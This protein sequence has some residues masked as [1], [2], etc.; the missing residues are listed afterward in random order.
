VYIPICICPFRLAGPL[1][2]NDNV[3]SRVTGVS[4]R[5]M[6]CEATKR[7]VAFE[8]IFKLDIP[9]LLQAGVPPEAGASSNISAMGVFTFNP[10]G[11]ICA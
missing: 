10:Q 4:I 8:A 1:D 2:P 3:S 11:R 6:V 9:A 5:W 7:Q